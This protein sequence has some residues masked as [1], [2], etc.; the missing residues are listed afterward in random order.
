MFCASCGAANNDGSKYCGDCGKALEAVP[1]AIP[2]TSSLGGA[3]PDKQ[4]VAGKPL[5]EQEGKTAFAESIGMR[6]KVARS[7]R[8]TCSEG[9]HYACG[10]KD[11]WCECHTTNPS[12]RN[13]LPQHRSATVS[14]EALH[15]FLHKR[16]GEA[17]WNEAKPETKKLIVIALPAFILISAFY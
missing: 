4:H 2:S 8:T 11:C 17:W 5:A 12:L 10:A 6:T 15:Q 16:R 13:K 1:S 9:R 3:S 14:P 7:D